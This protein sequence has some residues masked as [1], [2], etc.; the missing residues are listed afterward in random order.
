MV[1]GF[2]SANASRR[3]GSYYRL[4][5]RQEEGGLQS[6]PG[7]KSIRISFVTPRSQNSA[8]NTMSF[9]GIVHSSPC[10]LPQADGKLTKDLTYVPAG[11]THHHRRSYSTVP[12]LSFIGISNLARRPAYTF[13]TK[14][15]DKE[16]GNSVSGQV[17]VVGA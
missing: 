9:A 7:S 10:Q 1:L 3:V 6:G 13:H 14:E 11:T 4:A 8:R 16:R 2:T 12:S 17:L 5:Y 15:L